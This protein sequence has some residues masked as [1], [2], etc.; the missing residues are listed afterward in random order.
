M[1]FIVLLGFI[2]IYSNNSCYDGFKWI[3]LKQM[4]FNQLS[5]F[6]KH[7]IADSNHHVIRVIIKPNGG[8]LVSKSKFR[9]GTWHRHFA[10]F[11]KSKCHVVEKKGNGSELTQ[12]INFV[13]SLQSYA[14][15]NDLNLYLPPEVDSKVIHR[16]I[17]VNEGNKLEYR[18]I[19]LH[20]NGKVQH[21]IQ[22]IING[23]VIK[24][25]L[26]DDK[27]D[28]QKNMKCKVDKP[29]EQHNLQSKDYW[30]EKGDYEYMQNYYKN[31]QNI[32]NFSKST[33]MTYHC[34]GV[35]KKAALRSKYSDNNGSCASEYYANNDGKV[36]K[37]TK[38]KFINDD[39]VS[40]KQYLH[41]TVL[42]KL[43]HISQ[44]QMNIE[45][46][47]I[48][49]HKNMKKKDEFCILCIKR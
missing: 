44:P 21:H 15:N 25:V 45:I 41:P 49:N 17:F 24:N 43:E 28:M 36:T 37:I 9:D 18:K 6:E 33:F 26:I 1:L 31:N 30:T 8:S 11:N 2:S 29:F 39:I 46:Y 12:E 7:I 4:I 19:T 5:D 13:Q 32:Q 42:Q 34:D 38:R 35:S 40:E 20:K 23:K 10:K 48:P 27:S 16:K 3:N 22:K 47:A 14:N